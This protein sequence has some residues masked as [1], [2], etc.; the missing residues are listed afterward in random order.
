MPSTTT[1]TRDA[2]LRRTLDRLRH[3][4][5]R[6]LEL[7]D[8]GL[9]EDLGAGAVEVGDQRLEELG[10]GRQQPDAVARLERAVVGGATLVIGDGLRHDGVAAQASSSS[11]TSGRWSDMRAQLAPRGTEVDTQRKPRV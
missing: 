9:E 1:L 8:V 11:A 7:E 3:R 2:A 10:A 6:A 5:R 4:D